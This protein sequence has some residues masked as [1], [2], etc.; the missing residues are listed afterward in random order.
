VRATLAS[1]A[2]FAGSTLGVGPLLITDSG[3]NGKTLRAEQPI[4]HASDHHR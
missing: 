2:V 1:A 3:D 4:D